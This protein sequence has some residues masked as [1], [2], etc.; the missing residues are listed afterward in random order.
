M[1]VSGK[2]VF[3]AIF[4]YLSSILLSYLLVFFIGSIIR[5]LGLSMSFSDIGSPAILYLSLPFPIIR[6]YSLPLANTINYGPGMLNQIGSTF[7]L[8]GTCLSALTLILFLYL[9]FHVAMKKRKLFLILTTFNVLV[10]SLL[11]SEP[12]FK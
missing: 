9:F 4:F 2:N 3:L 11:P 8:L 12:F 7:S 10:F 1:K 6:D 5:I